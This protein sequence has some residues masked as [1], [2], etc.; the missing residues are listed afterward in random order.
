M[1]QLDPL[2]Q[3]LS[4]RPKRL[5]LLEQ[6]AEQGSITRAA[7]AAGLSYKAAWDAIDE[8]NN[9]S[10][11]P[12]VSRSVGGKG[13]G[14]AR[15]TPAGERLLALQRR[16]QALQM[17]LL[18]AAGDDADLELL[19]R[20]MLR[21]S[22]RNQLTGRVQAIHARGHND[23][24]DIELPGGSHLQALITHDS[25]ENLQLNEG[26]NVVALIKAGWLELQTLNQP[27]DPD[28]NALEG[29]IERILPGNDGPSEVRVSLA[30]GQTL[31]ASVEPAQLATLGVAVGDPVRAQF[32]ASQVLLGT[33]L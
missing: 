25:T 10:E 22:A 32:A 1:S 28:R 8:L 26:S 2:A 5:A 17:Q 24:V 20:L 13:G 12:L 6:I 18:Q 7:K 21:T 15:L 33:Q 29:H 30:N 23:L 27:V 3:L 4:R 11:Q 31:C 19:G 9:L 14:G 16:L